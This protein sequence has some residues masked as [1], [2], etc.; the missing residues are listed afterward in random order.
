MEIDMIGSDAYNYINVLDK[1]ADASWVR[2]EVIANNIANVDTPGF[3]RSDVVFESYLQQ[4]LSGRGSFDE[5][6]RDM[7]LSDIKPSVYKDYTQLSYRYDENN[8]D[9]STETANL[10]ENQIRYYTLLESMSQEFSRIKTA[11]TVK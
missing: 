10:A 8:V 11:L 4:S 6:V 5:K 2:N 7:N 3:K 1:A 9:I